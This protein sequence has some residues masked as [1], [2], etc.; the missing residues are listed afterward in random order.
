RRTT[1]LNRRVAGQTLA[2]LRALDAGRWKGTAWLHEKIPT[3]D[4][5]LATVPPGRRLFIEIKTRGN[6]ASALAKVLARSNCRPGQIIL[7]GFSL[8]AMTSLKRKFPQIEVCWLAI[9]RRHWQTRRWPDA[10]RLLRKIKR[11]GLDGLDLKA[12]R[13]I[14]S[15][16][17][18]RIHEAGLKLYVWTADLPEEAKKLAQAGVE[19]I[20]TNRPGWLRAQLGL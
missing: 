18:K 12:N 9:L 3:L 19:G 1:G 11:A 15:N 5:V 14:T 8:K 10:E 17:V 6:T 20:T 7:I 16:L 4:E 2:E 13:A